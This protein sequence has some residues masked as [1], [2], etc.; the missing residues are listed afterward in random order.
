MLLPKEWLDSKGLLTFTGDQGVLCPAEEVKV[1]G[2]G[3]WFETVLMTS[4]KRFLSTCASINFKDF[5]FLCVYIDV[6]PAF[7]PCEGVGS[8]GTVITVSCRVGAG[9]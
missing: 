4:K 6:L 2:G 3:N 1:G 8:P 5:F 7:M 9:N